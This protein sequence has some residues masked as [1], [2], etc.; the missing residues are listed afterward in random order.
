MELKS[1]K[2]GR[3]KVA[4]Y[5]TTHARIPVAIKDYVSF[6]SNSY[7]QAIETGVETEFMINLDNTV[8]SISTLKPVNEN[9]LTQLA[10]EVVKLRRQKKSTKI[11]L[12][13]LLTSILGDD[14]E[15]C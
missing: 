11:A 3:Y 4:P 2:G 6:V 10:L 1:T 13:K 9:N 12:D 8:E 15:S 7:K 14:Y 5:E